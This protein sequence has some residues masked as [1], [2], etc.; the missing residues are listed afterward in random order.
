M[1]DNII[2]F[3]NNLKFIH[4]NNKKY[5]SYINLG[6]I[7]LYVSSVWLFDVSSF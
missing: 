7:H 6:K 2:N 5:L 3:D 1:V 4:N